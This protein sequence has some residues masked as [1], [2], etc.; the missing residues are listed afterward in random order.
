MVLRPLVKQGSR[1]SLTRRASDLGRSVGLMSVPGASVGD[2][3]ATFNVASLWA[4]LER[5]CGPMGRK[6]ALAL[7]FMKVN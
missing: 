1:E 4:D 5:Y 2:T 7:S 6:T 3:T